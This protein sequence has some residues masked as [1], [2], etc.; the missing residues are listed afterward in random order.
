MK[1]VLKKIVVFVVT[2]LARGVLLKYKPEIV[3]VTGS[4]GKTGTKEA[5]AAVLSKRFFVVSSAKS[6]NSDIGVPLAILG[7]DN[8]WGSVGEWLTVFI[9]G[10][11]LIF[12]K[13]HYP[14]VLVLEIGTDRPDDIRRITSWLKPSVAVIT[15]FPETP[16]HVEF[17]S[18][19]DALID[20]KKNVVRALQKNGLLVLNGDDR[21]VYALRNE[22]PFR[23][24]TFGMK[25]GVDVCLEH[26]EIEY[27]ERGRPAGMFGKIRYRENLLPLHIRGVIGAHIF[28]AALAGLAVG[29][30]KGVNMISGLQALEAFSLSPGRSRL[31]NGIHESIIIDD[32]YNSSP[33]AIAAA[34]DALARV[35][36]PGKKIVVLGD[37]LEL[38]KASVNEHKKIGARVASVCTMLVTVGIRAEAIGLA[39]LEKGM[40]EKDVVCFKD[41]ESAGEFLKDVVGPGD[42]VLVKGSQSMRMEKIVEKLLRDID[43]KKF[44]VRQESEWKKRS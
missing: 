12:F 27:D 3:A 11:A 19:R 30:E 16:V 37:M 17:F 26:S 28:Y 18:S 44:L 25:E 15:A 22:F 8:P 31:L 23:V 10:L 34:L 40:A 7:C 20:E 21:D 32:S 5:I 13:N 24:I 14:K 2:L 42:I 6:F 9:R 43:D 36:V 38:G 29:I 33:A 35:L 1:I 41:S 4:V 39:A